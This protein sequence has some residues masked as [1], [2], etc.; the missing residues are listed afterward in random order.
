MG[1]LHKQEIASFFCLLLLLLLK[2][3][4]VGSVYWKALKWDLNIDYCSTVEGPVYWQQG[5]FFCPWGSWDGSAVWS[6]LAVEVDL[7]MGAV[8]LMLTHWGSCPLLQLI[9][10]TPLTVLK[11]C[12]ASFPGPIAGYPPWLFVFV[13]VCLFFGATIVF[14]KVWRR[15][16]PGQ[17][18]WASIEAEELL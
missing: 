10:W 18:A 15:S 2:F 4:T 12:L 1:C 11:S 9:C 6:R 7:H 13:P 5:C 17:A 14:W 3:W 8:W 16:S